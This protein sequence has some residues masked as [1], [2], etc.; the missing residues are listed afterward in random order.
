MPLESNVV[1]FSVENNTVYIYKYIIPQS[2]NLGT[3]DL[4]SWAGLAVP[5][6]VSSGFHPG[7]SF[8]LSVASSPYCPLCPQSLPLA[9]ATVP[10]PCLQV[11]KTPL[12]LVFHMPSPENAPLPGS[13]RSPL[14][15]I[16]VLLGAHTGPLHPCVC[17]AGWDFTRASLTL[18]VPQ[19]PARPALG[20]FTQRLCASECPK[21]T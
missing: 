18:S 5:T 13:L 1:P 10:G 9:S 20:P 8:S 21:P 12:G 11:Q 3:S 19:L 16:M 4:P 14:S 2:S 6:A 15:V 17:S 7:F